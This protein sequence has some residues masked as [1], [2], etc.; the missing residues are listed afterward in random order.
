MKKANGTASKSG[1]TSG[2]YLENEESKYNDEEEDYPKRS[3]SAKA[4]P[5]FKAFKAAKKKDML[6]SGMSSEP[7]TQFIYKG[8]GGKIMTTTT[9]PNYQPPVGEPLSMDATYI[10]T[11]NSNAWKTRDANVRIYFL[12]LLQM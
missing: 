4:R 12:V 3:Q 2:K 8:E 9:K 1:N 7:D 6:D 11:H 10:N 5:D